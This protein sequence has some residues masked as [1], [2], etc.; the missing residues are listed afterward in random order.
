MSLL[1]DRSASFIVRVWR[2]RGEGRGAAVEWRGSI[3]SVD[4]GER[5]YFRDLRVIGSFLARH[6]QRIGIEVELEVRQE[7][8]GSGTDSSNGGSTRTGEPPKKR[9]RR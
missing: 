8:A 7:D 4:G 6:L 5:V 3:E 9:R 2:E 1:G